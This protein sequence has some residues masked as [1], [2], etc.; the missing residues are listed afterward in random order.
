M[1]LSRIVALLMAG[2]LCFGVLVPLSLAR[3]APAL[4]VVITAV[5]VAYL[6]ANVVLWRRIRPRG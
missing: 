4:A 6:V 1:P 3:R 2:V 5:F